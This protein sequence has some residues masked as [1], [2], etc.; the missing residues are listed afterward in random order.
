MNNQLTLA[1]TAPTTNTTATPTA[2]PVTPPKT[3][4]YTMV[5]FS[6]AMVMAF[7]CIVIFRKR[8][9]KA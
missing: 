7:G 3:G 6:I 9:Y 2:T 8:A 1:T 5:I 4:D